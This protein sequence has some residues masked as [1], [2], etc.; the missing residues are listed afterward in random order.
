MPLASLHSNR[1][2]CA[3][4]RKNLGF[5]CGAPRLRGVSSCQRVTKL[6]Q[7]VENLRKQKVIVIDTIYFGFIACE[8]Y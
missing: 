1:R 5:K 7:K 6:S 8:K 3:V 2:S 4:M